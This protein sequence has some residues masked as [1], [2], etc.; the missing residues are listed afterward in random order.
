LRLKAL[1]CRRKIQNQREISGT[2]QMS[3]AFP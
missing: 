3:A 1:R 2:A